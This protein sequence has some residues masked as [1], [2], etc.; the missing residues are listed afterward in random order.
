MQLKELRLLLQR[1]LDRIIFGTETRGHVKAIRRDVNNPLVYHTLVETDEGKLKHFTDTEEISSSNLF[2]NT[3]TGK[4]E[5]PTITEH[6]G[7][8]FITR[9][10]GTGMILLPGSRT[11]RDPFNLKKDQTSK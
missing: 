1:G 9:T 11:E 8:K 6:V 3:R 5:F 7:A 4:F 2:F 10:W